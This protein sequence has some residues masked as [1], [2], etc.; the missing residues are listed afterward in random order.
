MPKPRTWLYVLGGL[1]VAGLLALVLLV[2]AG[3]WFFAQHVQV[4]ESP[5]SAAAE[6]FAEIR[7][8]FD[9][10]APLIDTRA[11]GGAVVAE[12][13]RRRAAYTGPLPASFRVAVWDKREHRLVR[14]SFPFWM[15][16]F[17]NEESLHLDIDGLRLDRLG[18][19]GEDLRLAGPALVLDHE[20]G[21]SR[22]IVWTE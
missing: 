21:S 9:G 3:A 22:V 20:D 8:Q 18:V 15:L 14:L 13:E 10:Q 12:L 17:Q 6:T 7:R 16:R 11:D 4:S 2:G 5:E 19:T 1:L